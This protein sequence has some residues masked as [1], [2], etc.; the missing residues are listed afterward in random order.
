M[1]DIIM[2]D[3][4]EDVIGFVHRVKR[5]NKISGSEVFGSNEA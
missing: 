4:R 5:T 3:R 2:G 1:V